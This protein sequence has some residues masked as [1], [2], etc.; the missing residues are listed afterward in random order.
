[1][2][3]DNQ[4]AQQDYDAYLKT[5]HRSSNWNQMV[6]TGM[7]AFH[8]GNYDIANT[9]LYKAFNTGCESPIVIFMLALL[10]EYKSSFYSALEYYQ[11]AKKGFKKTNRK[12]RFNIHFNE[13]Y[14]RALYYSGKVDKALPLL[15][16]AGKRSKSYWLLKLLG[17]LSYDQGDALNAV[18]YL[19]RAVRV[20]S[21]DVTKN[22][23][24]YIYNLL[25]KLFL[26]Q[27]EKD[28]ALRY[29]QKALELDPNNH[30]AKKFLDGIQ[31]NYKSGQMKKLLDKLKDL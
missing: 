11:L 1:M 20:R 21:A 3:N 7:E 28:G 5:K 26:Y 13:N 23:L 14:G 15:R 12:H 17:M 25:G 31:K 19:E 9:S 30:E 4:L 8:S 10:N 2:T 18:S 29:Y 16:K 22:E 6:R 24:V 27:G